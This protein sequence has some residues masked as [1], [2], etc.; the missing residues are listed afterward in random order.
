MRMVLLVVALVGCSGSGPGCEEVT[1]YVDAD[2]DTYGAL[3]AVMGCVDDRPANAVNRPGDCADDDPDINPVATERCNNVDDDCDGLL[4]DADPEIDATSQTAFYEDLD[5]DGFGSDASEVLACAQPKNTVVR[6]GDCDDRDKAIN[7]EAEETCFDLVDTNCDG[8]APDDDADSDGAL[9]CEDCDDGDNSVGAPPTWYRDRDMDGYGTT[10]SPV[11]ACA[12]PKGHVLLDG[13]CNDESI[14]INPGADERCDEIDNDC[15]KAVD[16]DDDDVKGAPRW[17]VDEDGDT[18]GSPD[19]FVEQCTAIIGAVSN[20]ADCDDG[21]KDIGLPTLWYEDSDDDGYGDENAAA[22]SS[23]DQPA[24]TVANNE[25]CDDSDEDINPDTLW[26]HDSDEDGFGDDGD[27]LAQCDQPVDYIADN[28]DCDDTTH[29]VYPGRFD[30]DDDEDNDCDDEIDE[31]VGSETYDSTDIQD[32][33]DAE[34]TNCHTN[35]GNNGSLNLDDVYD[36]SVGV[37]ST[38]VATMSLIEPG[39]L[40]NSYIWHK[41]EGTQSNVG[42]A[43][44]QMPQGGKLSSS[45]S[46]VFET[47][48]LE[49]A[50]E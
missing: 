35:G 28:T 44:G 38:D 46:E 33:V 21:N 49:G 39:D 23:C 14:A 7:P 22:V 8:I 4:D 45:D 11:R 25:D 27:S 29:L 30:F 43:G 6:A 3:D 36:D 19:Y 48:I 15:D 37:A 32:I 41:L 10:D 18:Y 1:W 20:G 17:Y 5:G 34:C 13:D 9:A 12:M 47:W 24:D 50:I 16:D 2:G 31:D 40:R 42:G 26:Y